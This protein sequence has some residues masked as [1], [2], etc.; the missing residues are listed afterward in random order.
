MAPPLPV[1]PPAGSDAGGQG[2]AISNQI[3]DDPQ[4]RQYRQQQ[5]N[6][7]YR[8]SAAGASTH[9]N[10]PRR[11][12]RTYGTG[13]HELHDVSTQDVTVPP[14]GHRTSVS[15]DAEYPYDRSGSNPPRGNLSRVGDPPDDTENLT[16]HRPH[17]RN[18]TSS[19][20]SLR[21]PLSPRPEVQDWAG[22]RGHSSS[23]SLASGGNQRAAQQQNS[24]DIRDVV[25]PPATPESL[26]ARGLE[27]H[28]ERGR[29]EG[30]WQNRDD[31]ASAVGAGDDGVENTE[32][33]RLGLQVGSPLDVKDT[34]D[35]WCE[36]T[37]KRVDRERQQVFITYTYWSSKVRKTS[38]C[39]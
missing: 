23:R 24:A 35:K 7:E 12:N 16:S 39:W 36:A 3:A 15:S 20:S 34:V 37:V 26:G 25:R 11:S 6:T 8:D 27:D 28:G 13:F 19:A 21:S 2:S 31:G 38:A 10:R 18:L 33:W 9:S 30:G 17:T 4:Q 32:A 29:P 22:D 1:L 5:F 14:S